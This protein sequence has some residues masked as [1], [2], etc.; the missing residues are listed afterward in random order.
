MD[1]G[2]KA[3]GGNGFPYRT[4]NVRINIVEREM[5]ISKRNGNIRE[6]GDRR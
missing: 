2:G 6:D 1:F 4:T 3:F 5:G